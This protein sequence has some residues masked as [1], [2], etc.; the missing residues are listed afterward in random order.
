MNQALMMRCSGYVLSMIVILADYLTK[1]WAM[2]H[3]VPYESYAVLPIMNWT[4]AFNTGSAFS[5]LENTGSWHTWVL[6][7]FSLLM[8][9]AIGIWMSR[10]SFV[11]QKLE[12]YSLSL[13]LGGALGNL[14]DRV[15]FGYVIDFIDVFYKNYH[16]PVFNVA[17]S[18]ICIGGS[19]LLIDMFFKKKSVPEKA[20]N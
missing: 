5:F 8:S 6:G 19:L 7:A 2:S 14:F 11:K 12:F 1:F 17:D 10:L 18:A 20:C 9:V 16:W 4:L 15:R 3:L 13:V